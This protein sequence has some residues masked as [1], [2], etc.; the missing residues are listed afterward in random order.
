MHLVYINPNAT[1]TMT[2]AVV[3]VAR[4]HVPNAIVSGLTNT[5]GPAAIEGPEDGD[6]AIPGMLSLLEDAKAL[7][8]DAI[9]IACF[10]DTGLAQ[11]QAASPCPVYGIGQAAYIMGARAQGGFSV[12]TSVQVAV[13]VIAAN[14][15]AQGAQAAC[16]GVH[17]SGLAVLDIDEGTIQVRAAL[18][19]AIGVAFERDGSGAVVLGC[20]G[21][22]PLLEDLEERC[23]IPLIDGVRASAQLAC[24]K[25]GAVSDVVNS[26]P[27]GTCR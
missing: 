21:M 7:G 11:A 18:A 23:G 14:I 17:A 16:R 26:F 3:K 13:P 1:Q 19:A 8:A 27:N 6:A 2:D 15:E 24:A 20:A 12:V 9:V 25:E 22:S 4:H 10:D 5:K